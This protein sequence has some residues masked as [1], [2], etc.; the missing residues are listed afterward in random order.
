LQWDPEQS[1]YE[2]LEKMLAGYLS[3]QRSQC[4]SDGRLDRAYSS[5]LLVG[6]WSD[7]VQFLFGEMKILNALVLAA[8]LVCA[9][10]LLIGYA[11]DS[12][13]LKALAAYVGWFLSAYSVVAYLVAS[14]ILVSQRSQGGRGFWS[15]LYPVNFGLALFALSL[16]GI[17][18]V[19]AVLRMA[20]VA[21]VMG[22][23]S[24][25]ISRSRVLDRRGTPLMVLLLLVP[26]FLDSV[27]A[28]WP[29]ILVALGAFVLSSSLAVFI[30]D[31]HSI[32]LPRALE[33]R[34]SGKRSNT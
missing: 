12:G 5:N 17:H 15:T 33:M 11:I 21:V 18:D 26:V 6:L 32:G 9:A 14:L 8:L 13:T 25:F 2:L 30:S 27:L 22:V 29:Y 34:K 28:F 24:Y 23:V 1:E 19:R 31:R 20:L 7:A 3:W 10:V 4:A 16:F